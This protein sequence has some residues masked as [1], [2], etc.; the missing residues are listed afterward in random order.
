MM[1]TSSYS[2]LEEKFYPLIFLFQITEVA[3]VTE[4]KADRKRRGFCFVTFESED[5][6]EHVCTENEGFHQ[7]DP[8]VKV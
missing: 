6:A 1:V 2:C 5:V 7:I 8:N 4:K 3:L